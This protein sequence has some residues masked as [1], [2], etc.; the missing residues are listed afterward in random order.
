MLA[1]VFI[2]LA[3][4]LLATQGRTVRH[5]E[6]GLELPVMDDYEASPVPSGEHL[7]R[8]R[9]RAR[10]SITG[11]ARAQVSIVVL[12]RRPER[13]GDPT[14]AEAYLA[15]DLPGWS[16][17]S[18]R[19]GSRRFGHEPSAF[20]VSSTENGLAGHVHSWASSWQTVLFI[21][22][23]DEREARTLRRRWKGLAERMKFVEPT[24]SEAELN[25]L[26]R[27]YGQKR[28]A[29]SDLRIE[30]RMELLDG[31]DALDGEHH[32]F[33]YPEEVG[34]LAA[35]LL[36]DAS[37]MW[38]EFEQAFEL[39]DVSGTGVVRVCRDQAEYVSYGGSPTSAGF[40][41]PNARELVIYTAGASEEDR[42]A[43]RLVFFHEAF[44]QFT[45]YATGGLTPH[46][47]FD[48]GLA[49]YFSAA[50]FERGRMARIEMHPWRKDRA[51]EIVTRQEDLPWEQVFEFDHTRFYA[52]GDLLY[53]QSWSLVW[54][55]E[56]SQSRQRAYR[57][58]IPRYFQE[59]HQASQRERA[60]LGVGSHR[61]ARMGALVRAREAAL[62][63]A[64]QGIDV[65]EL[66]E[67][68]RA[69]VRGL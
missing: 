4:P 21:G 38:S 44:H 5:D 55:L 13:R 67:A 17:E 56:S 61:T 39:G 59:L 60:K 10:E 9:F 23:G 15:R 26:R 52:T 22:I 65:G 32:L 14:T 43:M 54:F 47:W 31:W 42:A 27:F 58:I 18:V 50:Q 51:K 29:D 36:E 16:V 34:D 7:L 57:K 1:L 11:Q 45:W 28:L 53:A 40:W 64:L 68:W 24:S 63:S 69:S 2:G 6:L 8:L 3:G 12:P 20:E 19:A 35:Q 48:E 62:E 30:V 25:K 33:V 46:P 66:T 41:N 49:D 37:A